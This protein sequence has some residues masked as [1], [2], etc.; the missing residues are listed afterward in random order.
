MDA[1]LHDFIT[2]DCRRKH[3]NNIFENEHKKVPNCCDLCDL[4]D[5][6]LPAPKNPDYRIIRKA[7]QLSAPQF[8]RTRLPEQQ[9]E[10][11]KKIIAWRSMELL[12]L[13]KQSFFYDERCIMNDGAINLLSARF[14]N[15]MVAEDISA[16]IDWSE[17]VKGSQQRLA[18]I[19]VEYNK[20]IENPA[21]LDVWGQDQEYANTPHNKG[22]F[23]I[24]LTSLQDQAQKRPKDS[25]ALAPVNPR[26]KR[27]RNNDNKV[28]I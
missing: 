26:N 3:F 7:S 10:A 22:G 23:S 4:C 9:L 6:S 28:F 2:T 19:L 18:D 20:A 1:D 8:R 21:S 17:L 25:H 27:K 11:K 5:K 24:A 15:V 12:E 13:K 14:G 16:I